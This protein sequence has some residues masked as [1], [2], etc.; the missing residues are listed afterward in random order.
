MI[1]DIQTS[2]DSCDDAKNESQFA[3]TVT[4]A[5]NL[6]E[7]LRAQSAQL[8]SRLD[9]QSRQGSPAQKSRAQ[10]SHMQNLDHYH[11]DE[12]SAISSPNI[13]VTSSMSRPYL[14][15]LSP[16]PTSPS[17][18][19][20]YVTPAL[21]HSLKKQTRGMHKEHNLPK[22]RGYVLHPAAT[23][24]NIVDPDLVSLSDSVASSLRE[25]LVLCTSTCYKA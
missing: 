9:L 10:S 18:H 1:V 11:L 16:T 23:S 14:P 12:K 7:V 17:N 13:T 2:P 6:N 25:L 8:S 21:L 20:K 22:K 24:H 19:R 5:S 15:D 4:D 3:D